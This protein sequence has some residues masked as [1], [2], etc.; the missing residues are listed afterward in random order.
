MMMISKFNAL[1]LY[2]TTLYINKGSYNKGTIQFKSRSNV[3]TFILKQGQVCYSS[4]MTFV[5]QR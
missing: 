5:S 2:S 1:Y 3:T 4:E